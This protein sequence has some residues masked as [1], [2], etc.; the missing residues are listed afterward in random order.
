MGVRAAQDGRQRGG[1]V[2]EVASELVEPSLQARRRTRDPERGDDVVVDV[3]DGDGDTGAVPRMR[4]V[5]GTDL[6]DFETDVFATVAELRVG[7]W[8]QLLMPSGRMEPAKVSW[9]SPISSRLLLV[10]RRG[11]RVLTASTAELA[12]MVKLGKARLDGA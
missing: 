6:L 11:V 2:E 3:E 4:I 5:G 1:L 7:D 9:V 10:N 8:L 12:A